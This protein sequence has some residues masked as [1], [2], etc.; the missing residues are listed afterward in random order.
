[1]QLPPQPTYQPPK[2]PSPGLSNPYPVLNSGPPGQG[3]YQAYQ[4]P[5]QPQGGQQG[6]VGGGGNPNDYY[7]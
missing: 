5:K 7:R 2:A 4:P 1:M 3:A 6:F